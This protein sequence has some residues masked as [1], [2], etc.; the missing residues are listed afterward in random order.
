[1]NDNILEI[2]NLRTVFA[3]PT[4]VICPVDSV[5]LNVKRGQVTALVGESGS[6]KSVTAM[7]ILRLIQEP[8]RIESGEI[9]YY[10]SDRKSAVDI[11][12]LATPELRQIRGHKIA[13]IFQE[14][15]TS[16]NPVYTIGNQ[17]MEAVQLHQGLNHRDALHKTI[18]MLRRVGITNPERRVDNYP[19]ELSGGMRQ[20]VMIAMGLSCNPDLLIADE[21]T[22]ALDVTIQAQILELIDGL[23]AETGM[24]VLLITHD[25]GVVAAHAKRVAVMYAAQIVEE[26]G[27]VDLFKNPQHPYTRGLLDSIPSL[28]PK[29]EKKLRAIP[30]MVPQLQN[31]PHGCRF[32]DRCIAVLP[33]CRAQR[34]ALTNSDDRSYRCLHPVKA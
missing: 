24:S 29:S 23:V 31:L 18:E 21:P 7:S 3:T 22:T 8:G 2:K 6:G 32:Q 30:G 12:K 34:I 9:L 25:L 15:M 27:V 13:M 14:P 19:H 11:L 16:L 4:G 10:P 28:K 17:I 20:R 1:M 5:S 33:D 26:A